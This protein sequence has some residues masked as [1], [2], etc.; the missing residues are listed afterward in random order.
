MVGAA[1]HVCQT[2]SSF[3][4]SHTSLDGIIGPNQQSQPWLGSPAGSWPLRGTRP[5]TQWCCGWTEAPAAALWT[6][7]CRRMDRSMWA[8]RVC[9]SLCLLTVFRS[10]GFIEFTFSGKRWWHR[11]VSQP[12][13]LD[14]DRQCAVSRVPCRGGILLLWWWQ[15]HHR[16]QQGEATAF[17]SP[18]CRET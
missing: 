18:R 17:S 1:L 15:L 16:W 3:I 11:A 9:T 6:A 5:T 10:L 13:Q 8:C 14:Q 12:F 7:S 4:Y 2:K